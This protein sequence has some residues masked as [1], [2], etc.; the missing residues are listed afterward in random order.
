MNTK[1]HDGIDEGVNNP[2]YQP[3]MYSSGLPTA[4]YNY[5]VVYV[6]VIV[7][8]KTGSSLNCFMDQFLITCSCIIN[9]SNQKL[10]SGKVCVM[11][12]RLEGPVCK[13]AGIIMNMKIVWSFV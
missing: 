11:G 9:A 1:L 7:I 6:K 13:H 4:Y 2:S 5:P 12:I 3:C 10:E 8:T